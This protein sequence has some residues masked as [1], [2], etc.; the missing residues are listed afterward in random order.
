M[1][2]LLTLATIVIITACDS[3]VSR[4]ADATADVVVVDSSV[5]DVSVVDASVADVVSADVVSD[6]RSDVH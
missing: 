2:H 1:K 3:S 5:L 4:T 6:V